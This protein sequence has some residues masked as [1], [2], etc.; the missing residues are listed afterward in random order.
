M[1]VSVAIIIGIWWVIFD[2][3]FFKTIIV[4]GKSRNNVFN[5]NVNHSEIV[6]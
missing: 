6:T 1:L 4:S 3:D 5:C 2:V